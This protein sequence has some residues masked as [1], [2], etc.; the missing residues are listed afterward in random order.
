MVWMNHTRIK[1]NVNQTAS[2]ICWH[3]FDSAY[4]S[5]TKIIAGV[6][7]K[8]YYIIFAEKYLLTK[9]FFIWAKIKIYMLALAFI[10]DSTCILYDVIF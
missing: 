3:A 9:F 7:Q 10:I 5:S 6:L 4:L 2:D 1:E 8:L